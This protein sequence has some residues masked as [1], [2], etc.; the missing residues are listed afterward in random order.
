MS[1]ATARS[2]GPRRTTP[3][4]RRRR[5]D[6]RAP[7][8]PAARSS[9]GFA[10]VLLAAVV[11]VVVGLLVGPAHLSLGDVVGALGRRLAG[12]V[13]LLR[14]RDTGR[15]RRAPAACAGR[16]PRGRRAGG[17]GR[18]AAGP[19]SQPAGRA[20][21]ARHLVGRVAGR[22]AGDLFSCRGTRGLAA[23]GLRV[24]G[25]G[26]RGGPGVCDRRAPRAGARVHGDAAAGRRRDDGAQCVA[27]D[28]R[29][30][31]FA[32]QLRRRAPGHVLAARRPRGPHL[33]SSAAGRPRDR[34]RHDRDRRRTR[35]ISTRCCW[36]R[37]A[38]Q[39]VGVDVGRV[40][41][42]LV[43]AGALVVGA[44]VAIAGPIGFVGLL[45][46]HLL[47]LAFGARHAALVPLSFLGGGV[48][49][50][51]A[52]VVARRLRQRDAGRRRDGGGRRAGVPGAARPPT[53]GSGP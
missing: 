27:D 2:R 15:L 33:G 18:G 20:G 21:R 24:R 7:A 28:V 3:A 23:A 6:A 38:P 19:V 53:V 16:L 22:R 50:V 30:V 52:D 9:R 26:G 48:F 11:A 8:R 45:V 42:R 39:S 51:I 46:P 17:R 1:S 44:A 43:L 4:T 31:G 37:S 29:A 49:L 40:R 10:L 12:N 47:R 36:A 34:G 25:R 5:R 32:G 13:D 35:A 14:W 41:M